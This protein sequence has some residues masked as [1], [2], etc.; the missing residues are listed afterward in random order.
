MVDS[1]EISDPMLIG[2][3]VM[4]EGATFNFSAFS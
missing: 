4:R 3:I 2:D 1:S